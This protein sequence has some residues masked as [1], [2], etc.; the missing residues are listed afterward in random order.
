VPEYS[1]FILFLAKFFN[2]N[3][4][5]EKYQSGPRRKG[6]STGEVSQRMDGWIDVCIIPRWM[7]TGNPATI[8]SQSLNKGP[9]FFGG[10]G[11]LK[12]FQ[13]IFEFFPK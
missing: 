2:C 5:A 3:L 12:S 13:E 4:P 7:E 6:N 8:G 1:H 10:G 9:P 11:P